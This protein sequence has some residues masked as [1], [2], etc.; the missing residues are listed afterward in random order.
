MD[1]KEYLPWIFPCDE[2]DNL[3]TLVNNKVNINR[4]RKGTNVSIPRR[5]RSIVSRNSI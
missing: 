5:I 3:C 2:A 4:G 1:Y